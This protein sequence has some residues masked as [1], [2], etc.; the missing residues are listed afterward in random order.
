[1][2]RA[3]WWRGGKNIIGHYDTYI[4][5][6][7]F[8]FYHLTHTYSLLSS[9]FSPR[10][11]DCHSNDIDRREGGEEVEEE[12]SMFGVV[13]T[14]KYE[15]TESCGS[16]ANFLSGV[17]INASVGVSGDDVAGVRG[18]LAVAV[19]FLLEVGEEYHRSL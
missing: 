15:E 16:A 17:A 3:W 19:P 4:N 10:G 13:C 5:Y 9:P 14:K 18:G 2:R 7:N 12:V 6:C 11:E 1:M 8:Y